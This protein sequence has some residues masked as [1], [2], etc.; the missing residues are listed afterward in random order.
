MSCLDWN[1]AY[2]LCLNIY[3]NIWSLYI[4]LRLQ[5]YI[6]LCLFS[7]VRHT[8]MFDMVFLGRWIVGKVCQGHHIFRDESQ[9][10]VF[11]LAT[12]PR[13]MKGR[14]EKKWLVAAVTDVTSFQHGL[15]NSWCRTLSFKK[16]LY[17]K[18]WEEKHQHCVCAVKIRVHLRFCYLYTEPSKQ[19][20]SFTL[21][22]NIFTWS[23]FE[24]HCKP[25]EFSRTCWWT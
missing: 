11:S 7:L 8:E 17:S 4:Y 16:V 14:E 19:L 21:Y 23:H 6:L 5:L 3:P 2:I 12:G 9:R 13:E 22:G 25:K 1:K 10:V 20:P 15:L 24:V 18:Y